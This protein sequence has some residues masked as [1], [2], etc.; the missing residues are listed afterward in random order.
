MLEIA[1]QPVPAHSSSSTHA[2]E[3]V[4]GRLFMAAKLRVKTADLAVI[5]T[6]AER[7][8]VD[9]NKIGVGEEFGEEVYIDIG[10]IAISTVL[11]QALGAIVK[12]DVSVIV[13]PDRR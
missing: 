1:V 5:A 6:V 11:T 7:L 13:E 8:G 4:A 12:D 10:A 3:L 9:A 2:E